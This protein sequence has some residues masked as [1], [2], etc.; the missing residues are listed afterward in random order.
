M[1]TT[2]DENDNGDEE[3][4]EAE[5][6]DEVTGKESDSGARDGGGAS[7]MGSG[8]LGNYKIY[9]IKIHSVGVLI[10][11]TGAQSSSV[12]ILKGKEKKEEHA[13]W[14]C[15]APPNTSKLVYCTL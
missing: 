2:D 6:D 12:G 11:L 3:G 9:S 1:T 5:R 8:V 10:I 14:A 4:D 7:G 13:A 15:R